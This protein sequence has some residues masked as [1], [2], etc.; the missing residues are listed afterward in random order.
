M[1]RL[2]CARYAV[3]VQRALEAAGSSLAVRARP[4]D[5][6]VDE[7]VEH[8]TLGLAQPGH[9]RHGEVGEQLTT[10]PDASAPADL[11][12][13]AL[14]RLGGDGDPLVPRLLP[15][16]RDPALG[17]SSAVALTVDWGQLTDDDDLLAVDADLRVPDEPVGRE[18][19]GEPFGDV[20]GRREIGLLPAAGATEPARPTGTAA[21]ATAGS[22]GAA[23]AAGSSGASGAERHT[24]TVGACGTHGER[25]TETHPEVWAAAPSRAAP[26]A[27]GG[28]GVGG[29]VAVC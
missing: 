24:R 11:A 4:S 9:D 8:L 27:L 1:P 29:V 7:G 21:T 3:R 26:A 15:E 25:G 20:I 22:S 6:G 19:V 17:S 18:S 10:L 28:L 5:P 14:L 16:P 2:C 12:A 23:G 13:V